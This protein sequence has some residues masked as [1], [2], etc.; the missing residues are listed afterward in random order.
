MN[1]YIRLVNVCSPKMP[2]PRA[3]TLSSKML[4]FTVTM[5][6]PGDISSS[7]SLGKAVSNIYLQFH[8]MILLHLL[9]QTLGHLVHQQPLVVMRLPVVMNLLEV[10]FE[11]THHLHRQTKSSI[12]VPSSFSNCRLLKVMT[13]KFTIIH[14]H[15]TL[16]TRCSSYFSF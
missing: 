9:P 14:A 5:I 10:H 12:N 15:I 13:E 7:C 3:S 11:R 6:S 4:L 2:S 8:E 16:S 1:N